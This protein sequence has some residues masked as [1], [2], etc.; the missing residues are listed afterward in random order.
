[1]VDV[2]S[3]DVNLDDIDSEGMNSDNVRAPELSD[4][5]PS[6][7]WLVQSPWMNPS[8]PTRADSKALAQHTASDTAN[9]G[10][11]LPADVK[12]NERGGIHKLR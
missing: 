9:L 5:I 11:K 2:D 3:D 6:C 10:Y 4:I 8:R 7:F 12:N 1:M